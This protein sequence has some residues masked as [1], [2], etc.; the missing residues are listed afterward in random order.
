MTSTLTF[1]VE[2]EFLI[3]TLSDD[4][5]D[6][7]PTDPRRVKGLLQPVVDFSD[8]L[9]SFRRVMPDPTS[10]EMEL[11]VYEDS[12]NHLAAHIS[13]LLKSAGLPAVVDSTYR[14]TDE[15]PEHSQW[16]VGSDG[17]LSCRREG[18]SWE[19]IEV[20]SP[21]YFFCPEA[22]DAIRI[23]CEVLT[24]NLRVEIN[25]SCGL[26]VHVGNGG[27][28]Y[29]L[30]TIQN[31]MALLWTFEPQLS[32]VHP[33]SRQ[34]P[35][36]ARSMRACSDLAFS[37]E[38]QEE[39][40]MRMKHW[41]PT[42]MKTRPVLQ[43]MLNQD[44]VAVIFGYNDVVGEILPNLSTGANQFAYNLR[45]LRRTRRGSTYQ[46]KKTVEFRQHE[47]TL[48]PDRT[49]M[50]VRTVVGLVEVAALAS[51]ADLMEFLAEHNKIEDEEKEVIGV[52]E[53][54][55][56]LGLV[57]PAAFYRI[58]FE[59]S[60]RSGVPENPRVKAM[61]LARVVDEGVKESSAVE[62]GPFFL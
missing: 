15:A 36:Y 26:H 50:W 60:G 34:D 4:T 35:Y 18:Y 22:L 11:E 62:R 53:L 40:E 57:E 12:Y 8:S 30:A 48:D 58:R 56:L 45:N 14:P 38:R 16:N 6:P 52:V 27:R 7:H 25:D 61:R 42:R 33:D 44:A 59:E 10:D 28:R 23:A 31:L 5:P 43:R 37:S 20:R 39:R 55:E 17:S 3:A 47:G 54:L 21:A 24:S 13:Q 41:I 2:F 51:R 32:S 9:G 49:I 29:S 19:A 1:G 46:D